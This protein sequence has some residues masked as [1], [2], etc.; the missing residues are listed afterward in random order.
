MKVV[1]FCVGLALLC[2]CAGIDSRLSYKHCKAGTPV[3]CEPHQFAAASESVLRTNGPSISIDCPTHLSVPREEE[4][5]PQCIALVE[6]AVLLV[7]HRLTDRLTPI[8]ASRIGYE[9]E[10]GCNDT[11]ISGREQAD[12]Y[13]VIRATVPMKWLETVRKD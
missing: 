10:A 13:S 9:Y 8:D 12:C 6:A 11:F 2:G 1:Y 7:N 4:I 3:D 5:R